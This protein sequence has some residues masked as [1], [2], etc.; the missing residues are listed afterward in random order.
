MKNGRKGKSK[1]E[2]GEEGRG[3]TQELVFVYAII[4]EMGQLFG[5]F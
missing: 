3:R 2:V 4:L 5:Y 1:T